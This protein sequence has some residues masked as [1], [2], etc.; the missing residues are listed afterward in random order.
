MIS[1]FKKNTEY[2]YQLYLKLT[3]EA[4]AQGYVFGPNTKL[5]VGGLEVEYPHSGETGVALQIATD[6][7]MVASTKYV[8]QNEIP[9]VEINNA[10]LTFKDGDK[11]VFTGTTP[12]DAPYVLVFEEW[13]T[14]GEWT[15]SDEWF[16]DADHHGDDKDI[17]AF[18]KNKSY[19]YNLYIKLNDKGVDEGWHFGPNTKLKFNGNEVSFT[20]DYPD[21]IQVFGAKTGITMTPEKQAE[22]LGDVDGD[23]ELTIK[24]A[25]AIQFWLAKLIKS[26]ELNLEVADFNKDGKVNIVDVTVIQINLAEF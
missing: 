16:N 17:T 24:D 11:P 18:D 4:A 12:N 26:D 21:D 22:V 9:V 20:N 5:K 3:D 7:T 13:R 8:P 19:N 10:T 15:R 23:G 2:T 14:D 25:T 1:T 6:L